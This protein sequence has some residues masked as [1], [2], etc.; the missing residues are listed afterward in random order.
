MMFSHSLTLPRLALA[1]LLGVSPLVVHAATEESPDLSVVRLEPQEQNGIHYVSGGIGLDESQALLQTQGYNLHMTF[2]IGKGNQ[3]QSNVDVVIQSEK[4][5]PLLSLSQV[6]P[7]VYVQLPANK[8]LV[9]ATFNGHEERHTIALD[10]KSV[11]TLN[12][13]W[14]E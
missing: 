2:S 5:S 4:G 1:L 8:Y 10:G 13:H 11:E 6:G 3:Y 7:I 9:I 14:S 12:L